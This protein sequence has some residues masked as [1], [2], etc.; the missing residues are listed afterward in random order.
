MTEV[1]KMSEYKDYSRIVHSAAAQAW[2]LGTFEI[3]CLRKDTGGY[4]DSN[5]N[6][7]EKD[8]KFQPGSAI[9]FQDEDKRKAFFNSSKN[10]RSPS[11]F[12]IIE[13]DKIERRQRYLADL[14]SRARA[15]TLSEN[16]ANN[17][18][19]DEST[20]YAAPPAPVWVNMNVQ[21]KI[22]AWP[23]PQPS[24]ASTPSAADI[25]RTKAKAWVSKLSP[26]SVKIVNAYAKT[27]GGGRWAT[28]QPFSG[29][30]T[31]RSPL[32]LRP[33][34]RSTRTSYIHRASAGPFC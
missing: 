13:L 7:L 27:A 15:G 32:T 1:Q 4:Y 20:Y 8:L 12:L 14:E 28:T 6:L 2:A 11:T 16:L 10:S 22:K 3:E 18:V 24:V 33:S 29:R 34:V 5:K 19:L 23:P 17:N 21:Q 9:K 31:T 25:A 30:S 26:E